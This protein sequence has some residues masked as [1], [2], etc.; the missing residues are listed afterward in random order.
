MIII[1]RRAI[2]VLWAVV[3]LPIVAIITIVVARIVTGAAFALLFLT[4]LLAAAEVGE[5]AEIM[6]CKLQ[7][8]F[9]IYAVAVELG[10]L[11][12]FLV[13][14]EHLRRVAARTIVDL[15]LI[16]KTASV[17]VLLPVVVV[18]I[19]TTAAPVVVLLLPVVGIHQG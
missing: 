14:L 11:R 2:I 13:F 12:Q 3:I 8:I 10:I 1:I 15:V 19:I 5:Y 7:M 4:S 6:V 17:V 18:V 16:I 9:G